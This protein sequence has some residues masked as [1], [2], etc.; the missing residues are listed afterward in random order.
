MRVLSRV[1]EARVEE[2][3]SETKSKK[4]EGGA[5]KQQQLRT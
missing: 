4:K 5:L 2:V 3:E 1:V